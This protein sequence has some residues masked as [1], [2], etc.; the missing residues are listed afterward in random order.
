[1]DCKLVPLNNTTVISMNSRKPY[2][3]LKKIRVKS[4]DKLPEVPVITNSLSLQKTEQKSKFY[5]QNL[6][7]SS[8][9]SQVLPKNIKESL[10]EV[11]VNLLE[12]EDLKTLLKKIVNQELQSLKQLND[13]CHILSKMVK[14]FEIS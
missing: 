4:F 13:R 14:V 8:L 7:T 11:D 10:F 3:V 5:S 2:K 9:F 12:T 6:S 1:M